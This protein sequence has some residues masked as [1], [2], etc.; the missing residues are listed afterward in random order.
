MTVH[1]PF[2]NAH[3]TWTADPRGKTWLGEVLDP[4]SPIRRVL[5]FSYIASPRILLGEDPAN[6]LLQTAHTLVA[7]LEATRQLSNT[8]GRP[9]I[10][11]CHDLGG[12]I[13][14]KALAFSA[15]QVSHHVEHKY[16]IYIST[17]AIMFFG[18]PH[19]G[20]TKALW[21]GVFKQHP[22]FVRRHTDQ[23]S[24]ITSFD[25]TL[26][27]ITHDF[28][29]LVKQFHLYFFWEGR[30]TPLDNA[31]DFVVSQDSAAPF[32]DG[33]E[34]CGIDATHS[35]MCKLDGATSPGSTI[36]RAA[37]KRYTSR[38]HATIESRWERARRF[39]GTQ[40]SIEAQELVGFDVH[41]GNK[42][43]TYLNS[44]KYDRKESSMENRYYFVPHNVST[45]YT[46]WQMIAQELHEGLLLQHS[47]R[48]D[49]T[50]RV[51]VIYGLGGSGKTQ[52]CLK[53]VH[54]YRKR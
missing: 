44:P 15:T 6:N 37:L 5:N 3:Q 47:P 19:F 33:T 7:D 36:V 52:S 1:G 49:D 51:Y 27:N 10:F 50:R 35:H 20:Y 43:F 16:S 34:R 30:P 24:S 22:S 8:S 23:S 45:F 31:V 54:D 40:R 28:A 14:K 12:I 25:E 9:I 53:F 2:E 18:T 17:Y 38:C 4:A 46:G 13:V 48:L 32:L 21:K 11:I 29:P 41:E 42:P 39:L 26:Q